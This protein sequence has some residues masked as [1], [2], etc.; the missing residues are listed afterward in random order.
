M[1]VTERKATKMTL[2]RCPNCGGRIFR[3]I[4]GVQV[5]RRCGAMFGR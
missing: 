2:W 3:N 5:C 4:N 1:A